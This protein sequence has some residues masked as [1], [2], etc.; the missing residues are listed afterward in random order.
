[1]RRPRRFCGTRFGE[2]QHVESDRRAGFVKTL[3]GRQS[4][5]GSQTRAPVVAAPLRW[6]VSQVCN[7]RIV[8][9]IQSRGMDW[10][11]TD[12][13]SA[14]RQIE[15]LRYGKQTRGVG[16]IDLSRGLQY[17]GLDARLQ[18]NHRR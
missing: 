11:S 15:N 3:D 2:P 13:K 10:C 17:A 4:S 9:K 8:R 18:A 7:L 16:S 12:Y 14:I 1:R 5:C 6:A